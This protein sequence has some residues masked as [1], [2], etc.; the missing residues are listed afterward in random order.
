MEQLKN[1][2]KKK[3]NRTE[4]IWIMLFRIPGVIIFF[5]PFIPITMSYINQSVDKIGL[6]GADFKMLG[7]GFFLVWGSA[8]FG[9][10]A[11]K[12]GSWAM[13]K[14]GLSEKK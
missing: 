8:S 4:W 3:D 6:D 1:L 11:N 12:L 13:G 7:I 2:V 9:I 5:L 10:L 14:L